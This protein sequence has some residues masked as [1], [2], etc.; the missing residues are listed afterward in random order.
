M[1][2]NEA[3]PD[4]LII[5]AQSLYHGL[6]PT[7]PNTKLGNHHSF[8]NWAQ[9]L[10]LEN[11]P[12]PPFLR[13]HDLI[14]AKSSSDTDFFMVGREDCTMMVVRGTTRVSCSYREGRVAKL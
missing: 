14:H 3:F 7:L 8:N 1:H 12:F 11:V 13:T 4:K 9:D 10:S 2:V 5:S 6:G